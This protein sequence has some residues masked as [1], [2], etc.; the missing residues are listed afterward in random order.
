[1]KNNL[2]KIFVLS[3]LLIFAMPEKALCR[4]QKKSVNGKVKIGIALSGG[5]ARG[6]GHIGFLRRLEEEGIE[7]DM[8]SGASMGAVIAAFYALGYDSHEI[9]GFFRDEKDD[10]KELFSNEPE[11]NFVDNY[12]KK[13]ADRTMLEVELTKDGIKLPNS[14]TTGHMISKKMSRMIYGS[15][16]YSN[17][18]N[19]LK[20]PL[21]VVCTDVQNTKKVVFDQGDLLEILSGTIAYPAIFKPIFYKGMR[22]VDGGMTDNLPTDVLDS[23]GVIILSDMTYDTP[24]Q[25][26]EYSIIE[27]L[28]RISITMTREQLKENL[29]LADVIVKPV[30]ND[31]SLSSFEKLDSLL[32]AGYR[33]ADSQIAKIKQAINKS[34]ADLKLCDT[35]SMTALADS[36]MGYNWSGNVSVADSTVE[37]IISSATSPD[38][39][40]TALSRYYKGIGY[41]LSSVTKEDK[42]SVVLIKIK[43]GT[44]SDIRFEGNVITRNSYI[45]NITGLKKGRILTFKDAEDNLNNLY[46]SDLFYRVTYTLDDE[47]GIVKYNFVEKPYQ[48]IRFGAN[49]ETDRG[50]KTLMEFSNKNLFGQGSI[51]YLNYVF[52]EKI[53]RLEGSYYN[54]FFKKASI[55]YE[56]MPYYQ[57]MEL[58]YF[59][60]DK[61]IEERD[62]YRY[63]GQVT[64]GLQFLSNYQGSVSVLYE[65]VQD[66]GTVILHRNSLIGKLLFDN[67]NNA[68]FATSGL[69]LNFVFEKG[70][71]NLESNISYHKSY[72]SASFY[73]EP[74]SGLN[75]N[76]HIQGGS[77]DNLIPQSEQFRLGGKNFLPGSYVNQY[78]ARQYLAFKTGNRFRVYRSS[79][80]EAFFNF[81]YNLACFW[82]APEGL[83]QNLD[84]V[85]AF[86]LGLSAKTP[87]GPIEIGYGAN[88]T[89]QHV[90]KNQR[91]YI[92]FGYEL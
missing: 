91:V 45:K 82:Q 71:P 75:L 73:I 4:I 50:F 24:D 2:I 30:I 38:G 76:L 21:R 31:V 66:S 10:I 58:P 54:S 48:V 68:F 6:L 16:Y 8:I 74:F 64:T 61:K 7:P 62:E 86:Y 63:G 47:T 22:L 11:R 67:R 80:T 40:V 85:N 44:I 43:E 42:D 5:G 55:F 3:L 90:E 34:Q 65:E 81:S 89:N 25:N 20:Y 36:S 9:E 14:L 69:Y 88:G 37:R 83:W 72:G 17:D 41:I 84:F 29:K 1:M 78:I 52:G 15:P 56:V 27:L 18:F 13:I 87:I 51:A 53:G 23:C 70:W 60:G 33:A 12:L 92:T 32:A 19:Q 77:A 57:R 28:D 39:A 79:L 26:R 46:G 59:K 49:Y 35:D